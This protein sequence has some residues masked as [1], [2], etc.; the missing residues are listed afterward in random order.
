MP[1]KE[2]RVQDGQSGFRAYSRKAIERIDP[3]DDD[4]GISAEILMQGRKK[5]LVYGEVPIYCDYNVDGSTKKPLGH[6]L[7]V[8][9]SMLKYM[10]IEHSLLFFGVPGI[11]LFSAGMLFGV[12]VVLDYNAFGIFPVGNALITLLLLVFG[13]LCGMTGLILHAVINASRRT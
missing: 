10:E 5:S 3:K 11:I 2:H 9:V 12:K 13:V 8:I 6:G 1:K 4:M 7:G